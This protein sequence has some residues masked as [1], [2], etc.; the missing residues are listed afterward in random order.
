ML[1]FV[2][3]MKQRIIYLLKLYL[4]FLIFSVISRVIFLLY[5]F[6]ASSESSIWECLQTFYYGLRLDLSA[7]AYLMILPVLLLVSSSIIKRDIFRFVMPWYFGAAYIVLSLTLVADLELYNFWGFRLDSTP[8]LYLKHPKEAMASVS[9]WIVIRQLFLAA[10][11][12]FSFLWVFRKKMQVPEQKFSFFEIP[13]YLFLFAFLIVPIRGGFGIAPINVGA[14]YFSSANFLN[15]AAINLYWNLGNSFLD[16]AKKEN[17]YKYF[18]KQ[19]AEDMVGPYLNTFDTTGLR[20]LNV[21]RP[22]ILL[23]MLESFTANVIA[24]LGGMKD[25]TPS[26][27]SLAGDGI[28][29]T[30]FYASGDRTDKGIVSV[31]SGYPAQPTFSVIQDAAKTQVLP[32]LSMDLKKLGY[33]TSF[34]YGGNVDFANMRS[35]LISGGFEN[36]VTMDS[37]PKSTYNSKWGSHDAVVFNKLFND[38]NNAREP[39]F[40]LFLTLSSH[41]PFEVPT[42]HF[43]GNMESVRYLNSVMYTDSCIGD[44]IA[45][46]KKQPWWGNTWIILVADHGSR[47][48][49]NLAVYEPGKFF[50]P[51]LWTGGAVRGGFSFDK[52]ASQADIPAT[53]LNQLNCNFDAYIFSRNIFGT[54]Q[55]TDAFYLFNNGIGM[56][57]DSVKFVFDFAKNALQTDSNVPDSLVN[58][59]KAYVQYIYSDLNKR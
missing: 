26:L 49:N 44:F 37:F 48:P 40:K 28:L 50:I 29:F 46:A 54:K 35:Y 38:L 30:N 52:T 23:I 31:L 25:V 34:Y 4:L 27:N 55:K 11:I 5:H 16:Q 22:N 59:S 18:E 8:V 14:A 39:F 24:P 57:N 21:P 45:K 51:M 33:T 10:V 9:I 13:V 36:L 3:F 56:V 19:K 17:N 41:E 47:H 12:I 58:L 7:S 32:K 2:E 43:K 53:V 1:H 15:H 20:V 42:S 6:S